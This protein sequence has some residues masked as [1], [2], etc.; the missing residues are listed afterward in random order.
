MFTNGQMD[1]NTMDNI[2]TIKNRDKVHTRG[3]MEEDMRANGKMENNMVM[4]SLQILRG[5]PELGF[6]LMER[7]QDG[8]MN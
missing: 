1:E 4:E 3:R 7:G 8:W 5:V 6:G 2:S